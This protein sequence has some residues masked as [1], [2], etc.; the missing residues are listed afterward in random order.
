MNKMLWKYWERIDKF[1]LGLLERAREDHRE[2]FTFE[3][4]FKN[5]QIFR[6]WEVREGIFQEDRIT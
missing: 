3:R 6:R 5:E 1:H 2:Q 4:D